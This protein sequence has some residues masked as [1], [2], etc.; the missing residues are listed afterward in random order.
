MVKNNKL[1]TQVID[2][3]SPTVAGAKTTKEALAKQEANKD[4]MAIDPST[5]Q[6][7]TVKAE[8]ANAKAKEAHKDAEATLQ[9]ETNK[10][11]A[12]TTVNAKDLRKGVVP[13]SSELIKAVKADAKERGKTF[14]T[15]PVNGVLIV[16]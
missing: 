16:K 13:E 2:K 4:K 1:K 6:P 7:E 3:T 11:T 12:D 14:S 9:K 5:T 8:E 10:M 15:C